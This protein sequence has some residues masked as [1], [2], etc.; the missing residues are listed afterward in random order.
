[1]TVRDATAIAKQFI[2]SPYGIALSVAVLWQILFTLFGVFVDATT[3]NIFERAD[4]A[5]GLGL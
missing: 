5:N 2:M 3:H 4:G 1:M